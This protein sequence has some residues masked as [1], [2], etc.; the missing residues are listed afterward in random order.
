MVAR[1]L[2]AA[3]LIG[4]P[5]RSVLDSVF[6]RLL[7]S[8]VRVDAR[9]AIIDGGGLVA[10]ASPPVLEALAVYAQHRKVAGIQTVLSALPPAVEPEWMALFPAGV[11]VV[12]AERFDDAVAVAADAA[13]R[14]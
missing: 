11:R 9:A 1:E 8:I 3:L 6:G 12:C 13:R 2:P 10:P 14:A 7:L 4:E 5:D